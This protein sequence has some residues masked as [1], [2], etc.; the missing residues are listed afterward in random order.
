[1]SDNTVELQTMG[2]DNL[3]KALNENAGRVRL[4][5]LGSTAERHAE[6]NVDEITGER[7]GSGASSVN[8]AEIGLKHEFGGP[9][10]LPNGVVINLPQRSFLRVP[11]ITHY[12]KYLEAS[13]AFDRATLANVLKTGKFTKWLAKIG[14]IGEHVVLEAFDSGGFGE[15]KASNM[16]FKKNHQTL[17]ETQQLRNSIISEV[18]DK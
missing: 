3:L 12:Q 18:T 16:D 4:G 14:I 1:M 11:L 10:L 15:W 6:V 7:H 8:N 5:I 13:G 17:V 2:L 9:S